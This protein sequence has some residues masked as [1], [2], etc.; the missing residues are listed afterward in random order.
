MVQAE[1]TILDMNVAGKLCVFDTMSKRSNY[2]FCCILNHDICFCKSRVMPR[3]VRR[4]KFPFVPLFGFI[5]DRH[6][7]FNG[8]KVLLLKKLIICEDN[9]E[10]NER[11]IC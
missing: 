9:N 2:S 11:S 3:F 8:E 10:R 5:K 4:G 1:R 6:E 7:G